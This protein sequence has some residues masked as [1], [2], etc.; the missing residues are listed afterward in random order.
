MAHTE[1]DWWPDVCIERTALSAFAS[2]EAG[3]R[4]EGAA[5][6]AERPRHNI[7][8]VTR[9]YTGYPARGRA[10]PGSSAALVKVRALR[11]E[12]KA[13]PAELARL[14]RD[15]RVNG[16]TWQQIADAL[17]MTVRGARKAAQL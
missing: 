17:D 4:A 8:G 3:S 10:C 1:R 5:I 7:A 16:R 13:A 11:A 14:I 6:A 2:S 9:P 12:M 15:C